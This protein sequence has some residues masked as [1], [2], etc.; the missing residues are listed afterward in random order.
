MTPEERV[1]V[2]LFLAIVG[3][4]LLIVADI[5]RPGKTSAVQSYGYPYEH[6]KG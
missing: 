4:G 1:I 6:A 3:V 5:P 2:W